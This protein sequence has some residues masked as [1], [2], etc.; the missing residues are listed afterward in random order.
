M[1]LPIVLSDY[2]IKNQLITSEY[3][4]A[5]YNNQNNLDHY[6]NNT[7][8][9]KDFKISISTSIELGLQTLDEGE[10]SNRITEAMMKVDLASGYARIAE[11]R[12]IKQAIEDA[13]IGTEHEDS[14]REIA[15]YF[16]DHNTETGFRLYNRTVHKFGKKDGNEI[17]HILKRVI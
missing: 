16:C 5:V 15:L 2:C 10:R 4:Q 11:K 7:I 17:F 13:F 9:R 3:G 8:Y 12:R 14:A 6:K 1:L